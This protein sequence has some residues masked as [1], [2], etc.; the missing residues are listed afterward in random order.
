MS[1][2]L[3]RNRC[4]LLTPI[5]CALG[6][7]G[8]LSAARAQQS[9]A[10]EPLAPPPLYSPPPPLLIVPAE[11]VPPPLPASPAEQS[12]EALAAPADLAVAPA[13][14]NPRTR[15]PYLVVSLSGAAGYF[16]SRPLLSG[17]FRAAFGGQISSQLALTVG[18]QHHYGQLDLHRL[19]VGGI[20]LG[21]SAIYL[22]SEW[23]TLEAT[24]GVSSVIHGRHSTE[25]WQATIAGLLDVGV[26][27]D[28]TKPSGA[29][30]HRL[31]LPL[32]LS[33]TVLPYIHDG[34]PVALGFHA[35]LGYRY[36]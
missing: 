27:I 14:K 34:V 19:P 26:G 18:I 33:A 28:L 2:T 23:L 30:G 32:G 22:R 3:L 29:H 24:L 9:P 21:V 17:T 6:L 12:Q 25:V 11:P 5:T 4:R 36:R 15:Q 16:M 1:L 20:D 10:A 8:G 13:P 35:G 31:F 7:W